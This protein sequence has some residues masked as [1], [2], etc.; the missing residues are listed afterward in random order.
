MREKQLQPPGNKAYLEGLSLTKTNP[1]YS[2][3]RSTQAALGGL[4][5]LLVRMCQPR[6]FEIPESISS[7]LAQFYEQFWGSRLSH[8]HTFGSSKCQH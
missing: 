8:F 3:C 6:T 1:H 7:T 5:R 4:R 2:E